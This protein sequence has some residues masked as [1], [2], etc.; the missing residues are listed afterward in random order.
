MNLNI[1]FLD[2]IIIVG[3]IILIVFAGLYYSRNMRN[4]SKGYFLAGKSLNWAMIGAALFASNISTIHLVGLTASGFNEG[5]AWGNFEWMATFTL[6]LLGLV[7]APFYFKTKISTLPE[8]LEKRYSASSRAFLAFLGIIGALFMH[9]GLSL[10]AGAVV[11]QQFFGID[12]ITSIVTISLIT[13]I[14]TV[15]GGLKAV[16]ITETIQTPIL[17]LGA[18]VVTILAIYAL[19]EVGIHSW[20]DL[21]GATKPRQLSMIHLDD[22]DGL[23]WYAVLLGYPVLGVWYWCTDQTIVQRVLGARSLYDAQTGPLF[24]GLL[25]ILPVILM[26]FPG[27]LAY[28]LFKDQIGDNANQA[29]PVLITELVPT[30]LMGLIAAGLLAAL[31]STISAALH[32]TATLVSLD[33]VQKIK[34]EI[35]EKTQI[36][37]GRISAVVVM[38]L[39]IAWSSQGDRFES[40]FEAVQSIA[41][42]LAPPITTIFL[43]GVF[44]KRGTKEASLITLIYGF[45]SG[46]VIFCLDLPI[47]GDER[48]FSDVLGIAPLMQAW[49]GFVACTVVFILASLLTPKPDPALLQ[50]LTWDDPKE[51][52]KSGFK[53]FTSP[54]NLSIALFVLMVLLYFIIG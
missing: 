13:T 52:F 43:L 19:P 42:C 16:V 36:R 37:I 23:A 54:I 26:V 32:S 29:L 24:A 39:S 45:I 25:K 1:P 53:G 31:M 15:I 14:Y 2:L 20:A 40:I 33:I 5:L 9:I 10:Y 21:K 8:F 44:W 12:I 7:F 18:I 49:W 11:F 30:G 41:A 17:I 50:G 3:Y 22:R 38:L 4:S 28:V 51:I 6:I 35:K 34:P 48:I 47:I 27:V 46:M